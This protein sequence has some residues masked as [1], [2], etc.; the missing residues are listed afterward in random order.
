MVVVKSFSSQTQQLRWGFDNIFLGL[1]TES[2]V[3]S[4]KD[5]LDLSNCDLLLIGEPNKIINAVCQ[6]ISCY[7]TLL[8]TV[9]PFRPGKYNCNN[10]LYG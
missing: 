4:L 6:D 10:I 9:E 8:D 2:L 3:T 5:R 1:P 7:R